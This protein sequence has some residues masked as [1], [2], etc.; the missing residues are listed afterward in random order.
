MSLAEV[1]IASGVLL[2]M[3][4]LAAAAMVGYMRSYQTYTERGVRLRA[5]AHTLENVC[6]CLRS[7]QAIYLPDT[8]SSGFSLKRSSLELVLRNAPE[9]LQKLEIADH[10]LLC[11]KKRLGAA[12]DLTIHLVGNGR[13]RRLELRLG[14]LKTAVSLRGVECVR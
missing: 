4:G 13:E 9:K 11:D 12:D 14:E 1:L 2:L 6:Q 8:A 5:A 10:Q 7:G 3:L